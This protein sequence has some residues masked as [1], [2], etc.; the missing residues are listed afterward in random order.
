M[1][2]SNILAGARCGD[3]IGFKQNCT[4]DLVR[5]QKANRAYICSDIDQDA[6]VQMSTQELDVLRTR[7]T[8]VEETRCHIRIGVGNKPE[9][10]VRVN[11]ERQVDDAL[12]QL[13]PNKDQDSLGSLATV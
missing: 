8:V 10:I 3:R 9:R 5:H 4:I 12:P 1:I 7:D 6:P 11:D 2:N 13:P